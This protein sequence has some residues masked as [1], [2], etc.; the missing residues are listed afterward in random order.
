MTGLDSL[1]RKNDLGNIVR[2][3][4]EWGRCSASLVK[5]L[6]GVHDFLTQTAVLEDISA[7]SERNMEEPLDCAAHWVNE[8]VAY[9]GK[10]TAAD[11][12]YEGPKLNDLKLQER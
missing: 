4:A 2:R 8:Y 5:E 11:C 9:C 3:E 1:F 6:K 10:G 12:D 7:S